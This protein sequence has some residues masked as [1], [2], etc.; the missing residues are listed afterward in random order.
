MRSFTDESFDFSVE[1]HSD[2]VDVVAFGEV[3]VADL[4]FFW[5]KN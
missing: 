2:V 1:I 3:L 4:R 5:G